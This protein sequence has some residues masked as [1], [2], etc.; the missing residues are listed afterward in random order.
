MKSCGL[1]V[2]PA[3]LLQALDGASQGGMGLFWLGVGEVPLS[4]P[5][6][7]CCDLGL[8]MVSQA[9]LGVQERGQAWVLGQQ[10]GASPC[11]RAQC[12]AG[13]VGSRGTSRPVHQRPL[14][15][16]P[17]GRPLGG[18]TAPGGTQR[19]CHTVPGPAGPGGGGGSGEKGLQTPFRSCHP[20]LKT[21]RS[22][23][24]PSS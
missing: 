13:R 22:S 17:V 12:P 8:D 5:G 19:C 21:L 2:L 4:P 14:S 23:A 3:H 9:G 16:G 1:R 18:R 6:P 24:F 10:A 11:W 20:L 15:A 7:H